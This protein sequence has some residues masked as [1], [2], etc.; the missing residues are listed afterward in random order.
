MYTKNIHTGFGPMDA[1]F[2][3]YPAQKISFIGCSGKEQIKEN[4]QRF[5]IRQALNIATGKSGE[6]TSTL[7]MSLRD[8]EEE[9]TKKILAETDC[10]TDDIREIY[11]SPISIQDIRIKNSETASPTELL[12]G[13][14]DPI[15]INV[16]SKKYDI[17][18]VDGIDELFR[19]KDIN[20]A[21]TV[22]LLKDC[23]SGSLAETGTTV[24]LTDYD[25]NC[26]NS[27][28]DRT[29]IIITISE[30]VLGRT[31]ATVH[32]EAG[33][34]AVE[35][36]YRHPMESRGVFIIEAE[37]RRQFYQEGYD[38]EHDKVHVNGEL[39]DAAA[40]YALTD[41]TRDKYLY[42]MTG[43]NANVPTI[44]PFEPSFYKPT[45]DDRVRQL[46]KAG[47]MIAAEIDR[48]MDIGNKNDKSL[49]HASSGNI[50]S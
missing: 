24:I 10:T 30:D 20:R 47:A 9:L 43:N 5:I 50:K 11:S 34:H 18:I 32:D 33:N 14:T 12:H 15:N 21:G 25:M 44:W 40:V 36:V 3:G 27:T 29:D 28:D 42:K 41:K 1:V 13:L 7:I 22:R 8:T 4:L 6:P 49:R 17:I 31:Q 46:A 2:D 39:A 45:P 35:D 38:S 26:D 48:L 16:L 19:M 23:L 37:R